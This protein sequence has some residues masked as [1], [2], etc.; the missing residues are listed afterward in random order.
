MSLSETHQ[1][2]QSVAMKNAA[3]LEQG[4]ILSLSPADKVEPTRSALM[5]GQLQT[6]AAM[7]A[8]GD[9]GEKTFARK[10]LKKFIAMGKRA[11]MAK[12]KS[13]PPASIKPMGKCIQVIGSQPC[14]PGEFTCCKLCEC[15][16]MEE[17]TS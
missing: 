14:N 15:M 13:V 16:P 12:A 1:D 8:V 2:Y 10:R 17:K 11:D 9:A 5:L 4:M 6:L 3:F 7:V